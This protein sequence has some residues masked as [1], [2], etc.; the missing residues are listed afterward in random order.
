MEVQPRE[1]RRYITPNGKIP[2][3]ESDGVEI[4]TLVSFLN[5]LGFR[6]EVIP[7]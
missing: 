7:K 1:I 2:L 6:L 5:E 4:Y 3:L